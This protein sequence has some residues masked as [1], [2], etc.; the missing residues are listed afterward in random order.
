MQ[1][2][3]SAGR[4]PARIHTEIAKIT[5]DGQRQIEGVIQSELV[6]VTFAISVCNGPCESS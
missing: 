1:S 6:F 2:Y 5:K 3:P 4:L